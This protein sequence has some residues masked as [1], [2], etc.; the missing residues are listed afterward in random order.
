MSF[1]L[2]G[3]VIEADIGLPASYKLTL[4]VLADYLNKTTGLCNPAVSA[5][6]RRVGLSTKQTR[7]ILRKLKELGFISVTKNSLGGAKGETCHFAIHQEKLTTRSTTL[8]ARLAN[9]TT[10]MNIPPT[11]PI[12]VRGTTYTDVRYPS[13]PSASTPPTDGSQTKDKP[14][15]TR[16][17]MKATHGKEWKRN[18]EV[19]RKIG[20]MLNIHPLRNEGFLD[21]ADRIEKALN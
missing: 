8:K 6:A 16:E 4:I 17:G 9:R 2:V 19:I 1:P 3:L 15:L 13:I 5:I 11:P 21:Y 10:P 12:R 7:V 18:A 20:L 14:I